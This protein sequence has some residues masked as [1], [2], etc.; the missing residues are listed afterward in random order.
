MNNVTS[1]DGSASE[2]TETAETVAEIVAEEIQAAEDRADAA[3]AVTEAVIEAARESAVVEAAEDAAEVVTD[4]LE[5]R[6]EL[7]RSENEAVQ[8]TQ[9]SQLG[10]IQNSLAAMALTI[11]SFSDQMAS[12]LAG[13]PL[14]ST[15]PQSEG[16]EADPLAEAIADP[17]AVTD[18]AVVESPVRARRR[19]IL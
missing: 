19:V 10:E 1:A 17:L 18:P 15:P 2:A 7:W 3:E 9:N 11:Q 6:F 8:A 13:A 12:L 14:S 5:R 16:T 4:D